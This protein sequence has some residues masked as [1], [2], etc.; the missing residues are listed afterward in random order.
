[1]GAAR[2]D[3]RTVVGVTGAGNARG[4]IVYCC[5]R[6]CGDVGGVLK[7]LF[8]L[9]PFCDNDGVVWLSPRFPAIETWVRDPCCTG[10]TGGSPKRECCRRG[11]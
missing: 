2:A 1:M 7:P 8:L 11:V 6:C 3:P 9:T 5:E 4:V 10:L